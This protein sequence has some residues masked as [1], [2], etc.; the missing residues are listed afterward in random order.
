MKHASVPQH[1]AIG[2]CLVAILCWGICFAP[3]VFDIQ[4]TVIISHHKENGEGELSGG[5]PL[6][7]TTTSD[8]M[9][10]RSALRVEKMDDRY[11]SAFEPTLA[12]LE[13]LNRA[14]QLEAVS[15]LA[16][17]NDAVLLR[18]IAR[19]EGNFSSE[20]RAAA[21]LAFGSNWNAY[22]DDL[23]L[24]GMSSEN[25]IRRAAAIAATNLDD[26]NRALFVAN[27]ISTIPREAAP[28][29]VVNTLQL[30]GGNLDSLTLERIRQVVDTQSAIWQQGPWQQVICL[31]TVNARQAFLANCNSR[32]KGSG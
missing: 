6:S 11:V 9:E 4:S 28:A 25:E 12:A 2:A 13:N 22:P 31:L 20:T 29:V 30:L 10:L 15:T 18:A 8:Q 3:T 14:Q 16:L 32:D 19:G 5:I 17:L 26:A 24:A 7:T 27:A 23:L 21:I 1:L